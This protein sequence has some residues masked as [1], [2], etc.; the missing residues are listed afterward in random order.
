M[1]LKFPLLKL[2]NMKRLFIA[3]DLSENQDIISTYQAL[4][5][6]LNASQIGWIKQENLHITL[7]FLGNSPV[8]SIEKIDSVLK[9]VCHNQLPFKLEISRIGIFGS[10][11][12]PRVI[13]LGFEKNPQ[14]IGFAKKLAEE[15]VPIGFTIDRQN[16]VPHL[17]LGRIGKIDSKQY[18]K[19]VMDKFKT[20]NLNSIS[21]ESIY[22]Y[23]ST[24]LKNGP[25]YKALKTYNLQG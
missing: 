14:L 21:L 7:K 12:K 4:K 20:L 1:Y 18:F 16:F 11:Y 23:E 22:L 25:E 2:F 5:N 3:F 15:L 19:S 17:T 10:S 6:Q 13:W 8:E 24:L 9:N